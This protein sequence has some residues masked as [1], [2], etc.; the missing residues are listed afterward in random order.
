MPNSTYTVIAVDRTTGRFV[1]RTLH[2]CIIYM[3]ISMCM[4]TS[5]G[6]RTQ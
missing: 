1:H 6:Q 3:C 5:K 2:A 4:E